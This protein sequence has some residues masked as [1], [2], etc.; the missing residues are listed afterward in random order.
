MFTLLEVGNKFSLFLNYR[1]FAKMDKRLEQVILS[2]FETVDCCSL[3]NQ[4][5]G[6]CNGCYF[7]HGSTGF[8]F[9]EELRKSQEKIESQKPIPNTGNLQ[10][11]AKQLH[12]AAKDAGL[13]SADIIDLIEVIGKQQAGA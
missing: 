7:D 8:V 10:F 11:T 1:R 13:H 5:E 2:A 3:Y 9:S 6:K 4:C 12:R